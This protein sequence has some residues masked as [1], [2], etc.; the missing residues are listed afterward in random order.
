MHVGTII[1]QCQQHKVIA[2]FPS[3]VSLWIKTGSVGVFC[4][5]QNLNILQFFNV[6][7]R[8]K[9]MLLAYEKPF[10]TNQKEY[11]FEDPVQPG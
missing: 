9:E 10:A 7:G 6:V 1:I 8:K 11:F 4:H 2:N 3:E 5:S